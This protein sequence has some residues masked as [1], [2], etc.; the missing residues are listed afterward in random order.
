MQ[1]GTGSPP[2]RR[3][4]AADDRGLFV[5]VPDSR[6]LGVGRARRAELGAD[7]VRMLV[8]RLRAIGQVGRLAIG[9]LVTMGAALFATGFVDMRRSGSEYA[10]VPLV[11]AAILVVVAI[12]VVLMSQFFIKP[13]AIAHVP[14]AE[15]LCGSCVRPLDAVE[16][17]PDGCRACPDCGAAW[18]VR[19]DDGARSE[20]D[21]HVRR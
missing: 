21:A 12:A 10:F 19:G 7:R 3:L 20:E 11:I 13:E 14:G 1:F 17:G 5:T 15:G 4:I 9:A 6:L 16:P 8:R 2:A 18:R